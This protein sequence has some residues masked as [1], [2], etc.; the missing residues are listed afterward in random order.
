LEGEENSDAV[1]VTTE[2][3]AARLLLLSSYWCR[4][5]YWMFNVWIM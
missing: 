1:T 3:H 2:K 5:C 4:W